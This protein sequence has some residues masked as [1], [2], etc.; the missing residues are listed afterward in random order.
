M[1]AIAN[2]V[3]KDLDMT[4][5]GRQSFDILSGAGAAIQLELTQMYS[6]IQPYPGEII[7]TKGYKLPCS[8]VYHGVCQPWSG[9]GDAEE[10]ELCLF[11]DIPNIYRHTKL[12]CQGRNYCCDSNFYPSYNGIS[13]VI[14]SMQIHIVHID[15]SSSL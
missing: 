1:D 6:A 11:S 3:N 2:I 8:V 7:T 4:R 15:N 9:N 10:V 5:S 12:L 14:I 13:L